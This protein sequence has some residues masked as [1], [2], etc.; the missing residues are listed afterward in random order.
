MLDRLAHTLNDLATWQ[1]VVLLLAAFALCLTGF[2]WRERALAL[3]EPGFDRRGSGYDAKEAGELLDRMGERG[4][5]VYAVTQL[6]LDVAFPLVYGLLAAILIAW[7]YPHPW[8]RLLILVPL[9]VVAVDLCENMTTAVMAWRHQPGVEPPLAR[10]AS[11]FTVAKSR[12]LQFGAA[13]VLLGAV[14]KLIGKMRG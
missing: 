12:G 11:A 8:A 6:T 3:G 5:A 7:L 2:A 13:V 4:R 14:V 10:A 9:L 1:V